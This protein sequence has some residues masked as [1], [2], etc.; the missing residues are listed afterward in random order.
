M[1]CSPQVFGWLVGWFVFGLTMCML[2][3]DFLNSHTL[4]CFPQGSAVTR[5]GC[6]SSTSLAFLRS[7]SYSLPS[8]MFHQVFCKHILQHGQTPKQSAQKKSFAHLQLK[9]VFIWED[10]PEQELHVST[11][12]T[13]Y[14]L[15]FCINNTI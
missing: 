8:S 15:L 11:D 6:R 13:A 5:C 12:V 7:Q 9:E 1:F 2:P 10:L 3:P 14:L 4:C